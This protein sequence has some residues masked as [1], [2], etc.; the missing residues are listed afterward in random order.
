MPTVRDTG[1]NGT[2]K[3]LA[4]IGGAQGMGLVCQVESV[5]LLTSVNTQILQSNPC[6]SWAFMQNINASPITV[7]FGDIAAAGVAGVRLIQNA[8][9]LINEDLRWSG[10]MTAFQDS[11]STINLFVMESSVQP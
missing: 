8:S 7:F 9:L 3:S 10:A 6:R 11:G 1:Y 5:S 2:L 4:G